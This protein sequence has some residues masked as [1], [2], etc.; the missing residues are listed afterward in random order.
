V[1]RGPISFPGF[2]SIAGPRSS[3]F[4]QWGAPPCT[5]S[6]PS[7]APLSKEVWGDTFLLLPEEAAG[8]RLENV[9]TGA[10]LT[11][12]DERGRPFLPAEVFADF[13]VALA[14]SL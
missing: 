6:R 13:P 3:G 5:L 14:V 4:A 10:A 7:D 1:R 8:L 9:F 12:V 11:V 2:L